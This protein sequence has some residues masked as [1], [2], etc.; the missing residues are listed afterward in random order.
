MPRR[1]TAL[2]NRSHEDSLPRARELAALYHSGC[3]LQEIATE[4]GVS[5]ERVRQIILKVAPTRFL[6][7]GT[8]VA[9]GTPVTLSW[10]HRF[11]AGLDPIRSLIGRATLRRKVIRALVDLKADLGHAPTLGDLSWALG[12]VNPSNPSTGA[13][14]AIRTAFG[15]KGIKTSTT[16]R[17]LYQR[18][19][20]APLYQGRHGKCLE[21]A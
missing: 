14:G 15:R 21:T 2:N 9:Q 5:R 13:Q 11:K 17:R 3:T 19:G 18:L 12:R 7:V 20:M 6:K 1:L 4:I 10:H 8:R 16:T